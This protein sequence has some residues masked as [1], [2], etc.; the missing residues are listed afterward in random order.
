M[1]RSEHI[2]FIDLKIHFYFTFCIGDMFVTV[3]ALLVR[4]A[5]GI[6]DLATA[7]GPLVETDYG[8]VRG[9]SLTNYEGEQQLSEGAAL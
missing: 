4:V 8:A 7:D 2:L 6:A 5:A 3:L 9:L 1:H